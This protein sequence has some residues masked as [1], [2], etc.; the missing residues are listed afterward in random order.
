MRKVRIAL[1]SAGVLVALALSAWLVLSLSLPKTRG[2][3]TITGLDGQ[4]EIV[5]DAAGVPHIFAS[6]DHDAFF[7]QGYVHAQ[8]RMFQMEFQRRTGAGRLSEMLGKATLDTDKFLRTVGFYRAARSAFDALNPQSKAALEAY[9][10]GI[11]AWLAENQM[12]PLE[13]EILGVQPEPWTVYDSLVWSKMMMWDLG[14]N[15]DAELLRARLLPAVGAKRAAALLPGYPPNAPAILAALDDSTSSA[16]LRLDDGLQSMLHLGSINAG[17]NSWVVA[18]SRTAS[19]K[20]ML[21][22]DPHLGS[23]IPAIWYLVELQGDKLHVTG[24]SLPGIPGVIIG[25]N[26]NIAWGL[27]NLGPD[28]QDLFIE[29]LNP[30]N[31]NQ[32]EVDGKFVDLT[33]V[34][35]VIRVKDV[36]EPLQYAARST[37]HGPLISDVVGS[38]G[39]PLALRW[40][41]LDPADTTLNAFLGAAYASTW[42]QFRAALKDFVAPSQNIVFADNLGNIGYFGPGRIPIRAQ[43]DGSVPVP[44]WDSKYEWTGYIPFDDLPQRYNPAAGF[45]VTANNRVVGDDYPYFIA[46]DWAPPYRAQRITELLLQLSGDGDKLTIDD[47][48]RIQGDQRSAQARELLPFLQAVQPE[49]PRE[50]QALAQ[51]QAWDGTL[52]VDSVPATIYQAWFYQIGRVLFEDELRGDLYEQFAKRKHPVYLATV[53][54]DPRSTWCDNVLSVPRE[55]CAAA[56]HE[57]LERALDQLEELAGSNM[58]NWQW[59]QLHQ[60]QFPHKPFSEVALLK[61]LFHRQIA[62]GGDSFTVN[63][64]GYSFNKPFL[65]NHLASYRQL[66][67]LADPAADRFINTTGQSGNVLS[68]HYADLIARHQAVE[69]LPMTFGRAAAQGAV[70]V[71]TPRSE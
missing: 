15:W 56:E 70:L 37:R 8:D 24:A 41:A 31:P 54:G 66:I 46:N 1:I 63:E 16:L 60:T 3:T 36:D 35:E 23:Q 14:G 55:D 45:I 47:M 4:V 33:I 32:Y 27:T 53:L 69:Y 28:V 19:G 64:A 12:L 59:G 21:A 48:A 58:S 40:T 29:R 25:H 26:D 61:P 52:A 5:R 43:G 34:E 44:G 42:D 20:P 68:A 71:L 11:N 39:Q 6:T 22:N 10:A 38:A 2:T 67:D 17:S 9:T 50:E 51:L 57:A 18:G 49:L 30:D 62:N 7:A 65:Q 13:F